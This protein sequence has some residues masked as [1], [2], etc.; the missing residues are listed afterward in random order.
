MS[1]GS[2]FIER[3]NEETMRALLWTVI[4]TAVTFAQ[5]NANFSGKWQI[6]GPAGRGGGRGGPQILTLNQVGSDVTGELTGGRG[7]GGGSAAPVNNEIWDG[8]V[9]GNSLTFYIW[10]G[11]DRPAKVLYKGELNAAGD[12]ITFQISG[13]PAGRGAGPAGGAAAGPGA[14]TTPP[15]PVIAKRTGQ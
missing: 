3:D 9:S 4:A 15:A 10:R 14:A 2:T 7:G 5:F 11:S 6:E 13:G 8:K 1:E 12:Q